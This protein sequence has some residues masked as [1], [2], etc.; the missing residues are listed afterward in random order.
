MSK[1]ADTT[2][3][4]RRRYSDEDRATALALLAL[5]GGSVTAVANATGF[6]DST[7]E[8]WRDREQ[9][10]AVP[11]LRDMKTAD[12]A[13]KLESIAHQCV[14]LM[15]DRMPDASLR[16]LAGAMHLAVDKMRL[17]RGDPTAITEMRQLSDDELRARLLNHYRASGLG[18]EDARRLVE[19]AYEGAES[20]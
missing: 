10:A 2:K 8:N 4:A 15:P 14:D 17:L 5:N 11:K 3:Q 1:Q 9:N 12:L 7:I 16:D 18:E 13:D 6:P 20:G 19:R